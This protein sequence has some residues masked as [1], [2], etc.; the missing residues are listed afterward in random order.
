MTFPQKTTK[1]RL[2]LKPQS[3]K[4]AVLESIKAQLDV[5]E[6]KFGLASM[7]QTNLYFTMYDKYGKRKLLFDG[8]GEEANYIDIHDCNNLT[9]VTVPQAKNIRDA[10]NKQ[11]Q[12]A[13]EAM[14]RRN[15]E[16]QEKSDAD[17]KVL[18]EIRTIISKEFGADKA[19]HVI[20][21]SSILTS[22]R[23][24]LKY[25][26]KDEIPCC[27]EVVRV[28]LKDIITGEKTEIRIYDLNLTLLRKIPILAV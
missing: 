12:Q 17:T 21:S 7:A 14:L 24:I 10:R 5:L 19:H 2:Q 13:H 4:E 22:E 25:L 3:T 28:A 9:A 20:T 16:R 15:R 11:D 8:A 18:T 26:D 6:D 23:G 27:C 1:I